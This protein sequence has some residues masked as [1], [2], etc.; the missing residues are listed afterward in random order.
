MSITVVV[1]L[2][3]GAVASSV[4]S[5]SA[6]VSGVVSVVSGAV[7]AVVTVGGTVAVVYKVDITEVGVA[8]AVSVGVFVVSAVTGSWGAWL[9][10]SVSVGA[11]HERGVVVVVE[12]I[13]GA[14]SGV[15]SVVL[16]ATRSGGD[17][18]KGEKHEGVHLQ[19][20]AELLRRL[21]T[22]M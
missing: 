21:S 18:D 8:V 14:L 3:A 7:S 6:S 11:D 16:V 10:I 4:A 2:G 1:A 19:V 15:T 5:V 17:D 12:A 13:V 9:V 20:S 22:P